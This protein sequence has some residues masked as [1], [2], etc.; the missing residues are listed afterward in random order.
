MALTIKELVKSPNIVEMLDED[1]LKDM[2]RIC[3]EDFER[4]KDSRKEWEERTEESL[5]LALQV[6]EDKTFPWP[7]ASNIKFPLLTIASLQFHA[8]AYP[9]LVASTEVVKCRVIGSDLDGKKEERAKRVSQHMSYQILEEDEN[10]EDQMDKVLITMPII[11]CA[12]KKT[13]FNASKGHNVSE[14]ILAKDLVVPYFTKSLD[15]AQRISHVLYLTKNDV[16]ERVARGIY[17]EFET[18]VAP[19]T[20][21]NSDLLQVAQDEAQGFHKPQYTQNDPYEIIEQHRYWDLDDDG[22]EEPYIFTIRK[23]TRQVLRIVARYFEDDVTYGRNKQILSIKGENYFTKYP[24]VPSPDGG[25]YDLGFGI[26]LGPLNESINTLINQLVDAGTMANTGGGFLGRGVKIKGGDYSFKPMEWKRVDSTG[27]DLRKSIVP[28]TIRE[29][30]QTLFTLL[31]LL[32]SYGERI[33]GATDIMTGVTPGQNTPAETARTAVTQGQKIFS[34]IFKR[35]YRSLKEEFRKLYRLNQIY[36]PANLDFQNTFVVK[37]DYLGP[38]TDVVPNAD[39]NVAGEE[40][41]MQQAQSLMQIS[42][43]QP[44]FNRYEVTKRFLNAIN[45]SD[46]D[47]IYPNPQGPNAIPPAPNPKVQI[48]QMKQ[49][50]KQLDAQ[51]KMKFGMMKLMAEADVNRAKINKL[52]AE[53]I[54]AL[55]EAQGV[56]TGHQIALLQTQIGAA[57]AHQ[58]GILKAVEV[59]KDTMQQLEKGEDSE[60]SRLEGMDAQPGYGGSIQAPSQAQGADLS[61]MG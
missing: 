58:E 13:Y 43:S 7:D 26:L 22:Y 32:I 25:F 27:D 23:D 60:R 39:P 53:A 31:S 48:E 2:G 41:R 5:K 46:V 1:T 47:K 3:I 10:W 12:F 17:A 9:A 61:F 52:E 24:F 49:Q 40:Q 44:G 42:M 56:D 50:T 38:A 54:K 57:K 51:I 59:M 20:G 8:R 19:S 6:V 37:Q 28:L 30:S 21:L 29:P 55:A 11:G 16:Y 45:I 14:N 35:I 34:G 18:D 36:L 15:T 33:A 4:D